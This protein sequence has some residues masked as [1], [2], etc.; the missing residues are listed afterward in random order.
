VSYYDFRSNTGVPTT[1]LTDYWLARSIDG[2]TWTESRITGPFDLAIAPVAEGLFLGD[3]QALT[4]IGTLF[5]PFYVQTNTGDA[6]NR[7]DVF[8]TLAS[9]VGTARALV[10]EAKESGM[11]S[12]A[13]EPM[14]MTP[15]LAQKLRDAAITAA[16]RRRMR[17]SQPTSPQSP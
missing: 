5:V 8:A 2:V 12:V 16:Q 10:A 3:Y 4:S 6:A 14:A 13:A 15:Q 7:T 11:P 17:G 9:S 1:I